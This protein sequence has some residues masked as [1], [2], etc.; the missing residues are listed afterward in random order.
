[1][2]SALAGFAPTTLEWTELPGVAGN[3]DTAGDSGPRVLLGEP[4]SVSI[5]RT[6]SPPQG[7]RYDGPREVC[8]APVGLWNLVV[9]TTNV[10]D[11]RVAQ[12]RSMVLEAF[13]PTLHD[14]YL[15]DDVLSD[16]VRAT[17][18]PEWVATC[19]ADFGHPD[20]H[21]ALDATWFTFGGA[22]D[23]LRGGVSI[24]MNLWFDGRDLYGVRSCADGTFR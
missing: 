16:D 22:L 18:D 14:L 4:A 7:V 6:A 19:L 8:P 11:G 24:G 1:V 2:G 9:V 13:G 12:K 17:V 3:G 15:I 21:P 23:E 20:F 10:G 5:A